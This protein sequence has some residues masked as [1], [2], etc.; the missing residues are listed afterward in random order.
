[1]KEKRKYADRAKY[2]IVAVTKRRKKFVIRLLNL[3]AEN[4]ICGYDKCNAALGFHHIDKK[5]KISDCR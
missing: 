4:V 1:M 5:K 3:K 2:L